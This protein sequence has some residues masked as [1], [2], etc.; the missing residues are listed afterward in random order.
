MLIHEWLNKWN[1]NLFPLLKTEYTTIGLDPSQGSPT[2]HQHLDWVLVESSVAI[3]QDSQDPVTM[4]HLD[5]WNRCAFKLL[6]KRNK[7]IFRFGKNA[8][9]L[10]IGP[11]NGVEGFVGTGLYADGVVIRVRIGTFAPRAS[12]LHWCISCRELVLRADVV[13][14][15]SVEVSRKMSFQSG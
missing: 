11:F 13:E 2:F 5:S 14:L 7:C 9:D 8:F 12:K 4:C 6:E 1:V 15:R 10:S 3:K